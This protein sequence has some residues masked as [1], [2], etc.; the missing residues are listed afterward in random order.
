MKKIIINIKLWLL[1]KRINKYI[2]NSLRIVYYNKHKYKYETGYFLIAKWDKD[3]IFTTKDIYNML[4][5]QLKNTDN[6]N[7]LSIEKI[8]IDEQW[9]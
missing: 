4:N 1:T 5:T 8:T 3:K 6:V 9:N 7:I 2:N